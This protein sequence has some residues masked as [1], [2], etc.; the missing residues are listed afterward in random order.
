VP[1]DVVNVRDT[2][3]FT[4]LR[5]SAVHCESESINRR[6]Q[7]ALMGQNTG[8]AATRSYGPGESASGYNL[9]MARGWESKSVED[10]QAEAI[11]TVDKS[12]PQLTPHQLL[13]K[14][15]QDG[16]VL[17]RKRVVQQLETAEHP[18]HRKMLESALAEVDA[19]LAKLG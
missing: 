5:E 12:K 6:Q 10:Q 17:T 16:L 8:A 3:I 13:T 19:K 18:Q 1:F 4:L 11:F 9:W 15:K 7:T 2:V 14:R